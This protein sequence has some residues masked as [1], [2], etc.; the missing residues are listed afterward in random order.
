M[1]TEGCFFNTHR[2]LK[3][4]R[5]ENRNSIEKKDKESNDQV[6]EKVT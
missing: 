5:A 6:C 1:Q 3:M 2:T 4:C